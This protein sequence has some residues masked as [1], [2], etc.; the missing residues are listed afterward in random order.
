[1]IFPVSYWETGARGAAGATLLDYTVSKYSAFWR[2]A[3][4]KPRFRDVN[5]G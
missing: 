3:C 1:M 4:K 2:N 5:V